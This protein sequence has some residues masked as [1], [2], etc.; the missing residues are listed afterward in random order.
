MSCPHCQAAVTDDCRFCSQCGRSILDTPTAA[1]LV[2]TR[3]PHPGREFVLDSALIQVGRWDPDGGA[4]PEVDLTNDDNE[5]KISRRHARITCKD[6]QFF[7]EDTGSLNGTFV[8]RGARLLPGE[9]CQV[10]DGDEII[11]GKTF[12]KFIGPQKNGNGRSA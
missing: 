9:P 11:L 6:N 3:G 12:F 10:N 2:I 8:N 7:I 1:K 5:A 4:F